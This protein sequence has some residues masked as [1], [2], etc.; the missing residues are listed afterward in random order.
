MRRDITG[1]Y[2]ERLFRHMPLCAYGHFGPPVLMVPTAAADFLEYERFH[3][4]GAMEPWLRFGKAKAYS[5]DSVNKQALLN[6]HASPMEK[7][8]WLRRYDG[9]I[10]EEV[11]PF[12]RH[13]CGG[14]DVKP[15]VMG[16]SLG[17]TLAANLFFRH[18]DKFGGAIL[19]SGTYDLR[20]YFDGFYND[21]VYYFN[22]VDYLTHMHG[23]YHLPH[24]QRGG[25]SIIIFT[26]QGDYEAPD[27]SRQLAGILHNKGIPHWLDVWGHDVNH[28]WPW[29]RKA[30]PMYFARLFG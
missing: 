13:D 15:V 29:W 10:T 14:G 9:Y 7:L 30:V 25:K 8:S 19:M 11:L 28:D 26:G 16:I 24:L 2:S 12:I 21:D 5:V 22:P 1:W 23:G 20:R 4:V 6:D 3:L 18:P 17:A 27:R